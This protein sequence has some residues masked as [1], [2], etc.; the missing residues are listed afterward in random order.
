MQMLNVEH[1]MESKPLKAFM[2]VKVE[3]INGVPYVEARYLQECITEIARLEEELADANDN[4]KTVYL[5]ANERE[6]LQ[7]TLNARFRQF[8]DAMPTAHVIR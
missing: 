2:A 3:M 8:L 6:K 7:A 4:N 1:E 5:T